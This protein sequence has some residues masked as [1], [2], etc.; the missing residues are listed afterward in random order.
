MRELFFWIA[1][2]VSTGTAPGYIVMGLNYLV[3][4]LS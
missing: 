3:R 1:V 2:T 4:E